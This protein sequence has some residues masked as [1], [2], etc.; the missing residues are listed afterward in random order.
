MS[1]I[2]RNWFKNGQ[3]M[4]LGLDFTLTR[5]YLK[6][7][8]FVSLLSVWVLIGVFYYLNRYTKRK[9]FSIWTVAWLF[10]ALWIVLSF[11]MKYLE[12]V[13]LVLVLRQWCVSVTAVFLL[14]GSLK[15]LGK[16]VSQLLVILFTLFLFVWNFIALD[17]Y[18]KP[19]HLQ[20]PVFILIGLA[21][22]VASWGFVKYRSQ[23]DYKG[24]GLLALGFLLWGGYI[25]IYP[26][27]QVSEDLV[28]VGFF[29][30]SVIQ[31]FI[32]VSMIVLVL[33]QVRYQNQRKVLN[34]L[35]YK[36]N[37]RQKLR[38]QVME[39]EARYKRLFDSAS[40]GILIVTRDNQEILEYN[41]TARSL[42]GLAENSAQR[43]S[44]ISFISPASLPHPLPKEGNQWIQFYHSQSPL[45]LVRTDGSF[46]IA[47]LHGSLTEFDGV[48]ACQIFLREIT[49]KI[50]LERQ[51]QRAEKLSA[52]GQM[53][54]G[55]SH[56]LNNIL[57]VVKGFID[58][59]LR[60]DRNLLALRSQS[61]LN[62]ALQECNRAIRLVKQFLSLTRE[63]YSKF[64]LANLNEL[65]RRITEL[66]KF[67]FLVSG[68][69]LKLNLDHSL[70]SIKIIPDQ[71][72]QILIN[73]INNAIHALN[74]VPK[75]NRIL[76]IS[77]F[78]EDNFLVVAIEDSGPGVPDALKQKIFEPFF[79]T[80]PVGIGTGL[81]LS[82][83]Y[84]IMAE[85][86]G[87]IICTDSSI[88][89]AKFILY[90]PVTDKVPPHFEKVVVNQGK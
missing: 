33:E 61:D 89:G 26:F 12:N 50:K 83:A 39:S 29:V 36:E 9:Y 84:S 18:T 58:L 64:E 34:E 23:R 2:I 3:S 1:L 44:L 60:R 66:R 65:I 52:L 46:V 78:I 69:E 4:Y 15:F 53:L 59:V 86:K 28:C 37:E 74:S 7:G 13:G 55:V 38:H 41:S 35:K 14:W 56:E 76:Q 31:L 87:K 88:G 19:L 79:T 81:G 75:N 85:H 5:E 25:M 73:I 57:T 45:Q 47:E 30:S 68:I 27:L 54:S 70:P 11:S 48:P 51:L 24:A 16:R 8:M 80:K 22:L 77:T 67:D 72:Q 17:Y 32:A 49:D 63:S 90:F 20:I 82:I 6:P 62:T 10:Y 71:M 40:E 43:V 21:S 42:L